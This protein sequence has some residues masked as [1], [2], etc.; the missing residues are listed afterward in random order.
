[1]DGGILLAR[2]AVV[3][4]TGVT[5]AVGLVSEFQEWAEREARARLGGDEWARA[6]AAGHSVS[7]D[8]LLT[9]VE[10]RL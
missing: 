8:S 10:A 7:I 5:V 9:D 1:M 4:R 3:E 6:Y 2:D